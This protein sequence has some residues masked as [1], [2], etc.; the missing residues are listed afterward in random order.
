[1]L[2]AA[3]LSGPVAGLVL[4][5]LSWMSGGPLGNGRLAE[6]GPVPWQVAL[7]ATIVVAVSA[8]IGAAAGRAFR[9]PARK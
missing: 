8:S 2:G 7:V 9:A 5:V 6:I 1:M 4:G 3:L